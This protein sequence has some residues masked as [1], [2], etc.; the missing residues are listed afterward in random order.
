MAAIIE[1]H[2]L[3]KSFGSLQAI[4]SL[5]LEIGSGASTG[6]VGPN[7]AGKTTLFSLFCGFLHPDRGS[8][9]ILGYRPDA[10]ALKGRISILPQ[11]IPL[12]RSISIRE[13]LNLFARLQGFSKPAAAAEVD[14]ILSLVEVNDLARQFPETLSYGQRKKVTLAQ[15]LL[16]RPD[17]ILLDEP[18][19][20]LD[21]VAARHVRSII[22]QAGESHTCIVSSH[23][24]DEIKNVCDEVI[25]IDKGRLVEHCRIDELLGQNNNLSVLL[26]QAPP[27][28]LLQLLKADNA[29]VHLSQEAPGNRRLSITFRNEPP[30][31]FQQRLL[32]LLDEH[33]VGVI[34]FSRGSAFADK[35][36]ELVSGQ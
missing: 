32:A 8:I 6:L 12:C 14:R 15:A 23:N 27:D 9:R 18:T 7:G 3:T 4:Q 26:E 30:R 19:S 25:V 17:V 1:S 22:Q 36:I 2:A 29:I 33:G 35:V 34:E 10:S 31:N 24:L 13:Q 21:P 28:A 11:D 16:G 20:G 5:D